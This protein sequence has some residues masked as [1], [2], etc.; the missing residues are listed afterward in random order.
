MLLGTRDTK[1]AG[2]A[3]NH[4]TVHNLIVTTKMEVIRIGG[5]INYEIIL[6]MNSLGAFVIVHTP[7]A[8]G[9]RFYIHYHIVGDDRSE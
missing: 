8:V 1:L 6:P 4:D 3:V 9:A 7:T 5:S 2:A